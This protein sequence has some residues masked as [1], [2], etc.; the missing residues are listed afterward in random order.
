MAY[1]VLFGIANH[2]PSHYVIYG[3]VTYRTC[4]PE[5]KNRIGCPGMQFLGRSITGYGEGSSLG[6]YYGPVY[7]DRASKQPMTIDC[8]DMSDGHW[9]GYGLISDPPRNNHADLGG[10]N[11][12]FIDGHAAWAS[13]EEMDYLFVFYG[14]ERAMWH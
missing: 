8:H 12:A 10:A 1:R 6:D 13:E 11:A 7:I 14:N 2:S 4:L 3:W 5:N 9:T